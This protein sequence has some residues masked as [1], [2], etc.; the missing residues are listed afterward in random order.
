M[1]SEGMKFVFVNG[2]VVIEDGKFTGAA[3]G[4]VLRGPGYKS[5][6]FSTGRFR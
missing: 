1:I 2:V 4:Q 5:D 3:P 6:V